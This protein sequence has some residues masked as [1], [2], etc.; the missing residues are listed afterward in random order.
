[1]E[2][3]K[4]DLEQDAEVWAINMAY[5]RQG[6]PIHR[7]FMMDP[8]SY[9]GD[10]GKRAEFV[11][12]VATL[13]CPVFSSGT[14]DE[15]PSSV[16]YPV[17]EVIAHFGGV[18]YFTSSIAYAFALA[19]A[20][21]FE[22][23][24][25]PGL[26]YI[27]DGWEYAEQKSCLD[28]WAGMAVMSRIQLVLPKM[29]GLCK[30]W[31]WQSGRYGYVENRHGELCTS[32]TASAYRACIAYPKA[33]FDPHGDPDQEVD[34]YKDSVTKD[35]LLMMDQTRKRMSWEPPANPMQTR[36]ATKEEIKTAIETGNFVRV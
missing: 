28:F 16:A 32:T 29:S 4:G 12:D 19:I 23:I 15:L 30:P 14:Y 1:M 35:R 5:Q 33:W 20:E 3:Y 21:G 34:W 26:G 27:N 6:P 22:S 18:E 36:K 9:I 25:L 2:K 13:G 10:A 7:L 17:D 11:K 8:L 31:P 24:V